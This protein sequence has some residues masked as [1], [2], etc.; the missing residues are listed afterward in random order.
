MADS[1]MGT[2]EVSATSKAIVD[3]LAQKYLVQESKMLPLLSN[4]SNLVV[5]GASSIKLPR[6][7]GF[8]V[9]SKSENT[10]ADA[11]VIT[12]AADTINLNRHRYVQFLLEDFASG[13]ASVDVVSDALL[14][15]SKDLALDVDTFLISVLIAGASTSAPDH[16]IQYTDAT[17]EDIELGDILNARKLLIDQNIDPRECVMAIGSGQERNALKISDF[18]DASKYGSNQ[19]IMNGEIGMVYGLK[20]VVHTGLTASNRTIFFHPTAAGYAFAQPARAQNFYD[21]KE[22]GQ[23][24]SLDTIYGAAILDAGKRVVVIEETP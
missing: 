3:S 21:L 1:L 15:A 9:A 2:T 12:Y 24:W 5:K 11:S 17:N 19:P 6:S 10:S 8:S 13:Q 4:Y 22:L 14:K 18:I 16:V 7:G 20:V 23:R